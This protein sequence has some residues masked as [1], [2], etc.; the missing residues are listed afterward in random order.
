[1]RFD[2]R[3]LE[4]IQSQADAMGLPLY[5]V[6]LST[7]AKPD[8]PPVLI[9]HWHGF[10]R[11]TPVQVP[12]IEIPPRPVPGSAMQIDVRWRRIETLDEATLEAAWRLGAWDLERSNHRP[13]RRLNAPVS[14]TM[15]CHRA[16]GSYPDEPEGRM[17]IVDAPDLDALLDLAATKG[18]VRWL[19]RPRAAG[20]WGSLDE[21]DITLHDGRTRQDACPVTPMPYDRHRSG[22]DV[23]RLGRGRRLLHG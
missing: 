6:T 7:V 3:I 11:H 21:D 15:A 13:W 20:V 22:R 4:T 9:L 10:R 8:A 18:Y 19:F 1:M 5:A 2:M 16:F 17:A 14:E 23:Y 12:G